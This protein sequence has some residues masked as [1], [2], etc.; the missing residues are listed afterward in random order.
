M[1]EGLRYLHDKNVSHS[2]F[3]LAN[4]LLDD[5]Y[6]IKISDFGLAT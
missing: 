2:D 6:N 5:D 3:K 1:M 4:M